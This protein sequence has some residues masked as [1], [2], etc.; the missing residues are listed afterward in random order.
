LRTDATREPNRYDESSP[1][2]KAPA[3]LEVVNSIG[4]K[5]VLVPRGTF[6]MGSPKAEGGE[7]EERP[8]RRVTLSQPFYMGVYPVTQAEHE[9]LMGTNPSYF[10]AKGEGKDQVKGMDTGR[11]PVESVS[12][13][14]AREFYLKLSSLPAEKAAGRMYRLPTEAEWEHACRAGTST[15]YHS[16]DDESDLREVAWYEANSNVRTHNVGR[17]NPNKFGLFDMQGNVMQW[18]KDRYE[19]DYYQEGRNLDPV[20]PNDGLYR[21]LRGASWLA[22]PKNCRAAF[23]S[24]GAPAFRYKTI[25][26]RIVCDVPRGR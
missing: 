7:E 14:D 18:C 6:L 19:K 15:R 3:A 21:V 17:K 23:R 22:G 16:G 13:E 4:M 12:W 9:K 2:E 24:Q 8:Q 5:L 10:S 25:G 11:F 20:G 1:R 26:F